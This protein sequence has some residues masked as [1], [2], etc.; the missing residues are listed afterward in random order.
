MYWY[1]KISMEYSFKLNCFHLHQ[2]KCF[3]YYMVQGNKL[4]NLT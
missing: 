1:E 3:D 4:L 2:Y